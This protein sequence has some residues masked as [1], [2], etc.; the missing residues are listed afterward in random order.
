MTIPSTP[1]LTTEFCA[2]NP[3]ADGCD[4]DTDRIY[5][6]MLLKSYDISGMT[7]IDITDK[8]VIGVNLVSSSTK[9][10][11]GSDNFGR[12]TEPDPTECLDWRGIMGGQGNCVTLQDDVDATWSIPQKNLYKWIDQDYTRVV[13]Q[14][15]GGNTNSCP[16]PLSVSACI[17]SDDGQPGYY[18]TT[19]DAEYQIVFNDDHD[20]IPASPYSVDASQPFT[21]YIQMVAPFIEP[22]K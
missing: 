15:K 5:G 7:Q 3:T 2:D 14:S 16:A 8:S 6:T 4:Q 18:E 20:R 21:F 1:Y 17:F 11:L 22:A 12:F 10:N 13:L 19:G 9:V